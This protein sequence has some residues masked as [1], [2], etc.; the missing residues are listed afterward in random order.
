MKISLSQQ[1]LLNPRELSAWS[2]RANKAIHSAV[3]SGM[4]A[5][6]KKTASVVQARVRQR[7]KVKNQGFLK[8]WKY[9]VYAKKPD[10]LPDLW[11]GSKVGFS[12]RLDTGGV[13]R[14]RSGKKLLIPLVNFGGKR[15]GRKRFKLIVQQ[16]IRGG[17][18]FF[19]KVNG[20]VY[21]F[22]E[23]QRE[24]DGATSRFQ[25]QVRPGKGYRLKRGAEIPIALLVDQIT[26]KKRVGMA[27]VVRRTLPVIARE[28]QQ[29][30]QRV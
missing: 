9:H 18:A 17:N 2:T 3:K 7:L 23:H 19:K 29:A 22:A 15:V 8:S 13:V 1:G 27:D 10:K 24:F 12:G 16:L 20:K 21:L 6:G 25:R 5:G 14:A 30:L 11:I 26:I 4:T 28:I